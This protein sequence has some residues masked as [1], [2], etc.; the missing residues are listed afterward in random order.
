MPIANATA[1]PRTTPALSIIIA[2]V[3]GWDVLSPTL[4]ALDAQPERDR[5]EI[6]VV[7]IVGEETRQ[8]LHDRQPAVV[9]VEADDLDRPS[10]PALRFRG[11]KRST[12]DIVAILEDHGTVEP[13]WAR[14]LLEAHRDASVGAI[15]GAVE[16]GRDGLVNWAAFFTEYTPYMSPVVEG[17]HADL[18][19]NNIAYKRPHLLRHANELRDGRWESWINAKLRA[20][21]VKIASTN[22][23]VVRHI[24][25]FQL[26]AISRANGSTSPDRLPGCAGRSIDC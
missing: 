10:I 3:N 25:P 1:S 15:G 19:G 12:G 14:A 2:S 13:T 7:D 22:S 24:K 5:M 26:P 9:L 17:E 4:D 6:V 18:P 20:D 8:M 16:N 23:A 21:G 11:V